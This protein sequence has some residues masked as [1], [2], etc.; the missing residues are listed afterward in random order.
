MSR[1]Y[2]ATLISLR[3][4]CTVSGRT[5]GPQGLPLSST[6]T[7]TLPPP[8]L[9]KA[10]RE[11]I[12]SFPNDFLYST[13]CDSI[14]RDQRKKREFS[15]ALEMKGV[16]SWFQLPREPPHFVLSFI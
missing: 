4:L 9:A 2:V 7:I 16:G 14:Y 6:P 15:L 10:T 12:T 5:S 11:I 3:Y 13:V 1:G 8:V